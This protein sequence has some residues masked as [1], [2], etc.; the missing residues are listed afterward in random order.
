[1]HIGRL[2]AWFLIGAAS[3]LAGCKTTDLSKSS[4]HDV[5]PGT[6]GWRHGKLLGCDN[7]PHTISFSEDRNA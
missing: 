7:N 6:W 3:A 2:T 1:M 5:L 4:V